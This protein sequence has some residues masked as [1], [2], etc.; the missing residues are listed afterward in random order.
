MHLVA[1]HAR[2]VKA[3]ARAGRVEHGV[4]ARALGAEAE[5]VP[6]QHVLHAQRAHQAF[7]NEGLGRL[8]RQALVEGQHHALVNA[9]ARQLFELVAQGGDAGGREVGLVVHG[10]EVVARVRLEGHHAGGHTAVLG[11]VLEQGQ[12]GLVAAVHAIEI[13]DGQR[14]AARVD[15]A[16]RQAA[17]DLH[18]GKRAD[19]P[20]GP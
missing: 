1:L 13:A 10:G 17:K 8:G 5:I 3:Q 11:F 15:G 7:F 4:I 14:A 2:H 19:G 6:H 16:A 18:G 12:H 9:A 20:Q